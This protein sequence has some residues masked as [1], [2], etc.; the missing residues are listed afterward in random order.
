[1]PH[2]KYSIRVRLT[3]IFVLAIAAILSFTGFAL[4]H[5]VRLSLADD[6][7]DQIESEMIR[8]QASFANAKS[9]DIYRVILPMQGNVV[10]QVTNLAGT[11]IWAASSAISKAPILAHQTADASAPNGLASNS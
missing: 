4:V 11:K 6:A 3:L 5:L 9:A 10:I 7:S 1:M 8:T 2:H